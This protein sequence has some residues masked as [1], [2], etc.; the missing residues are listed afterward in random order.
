MSSGVRKI[1]NPHSAYGKRETLTNPTMR[2][3]WDI[4]DPY[5]WRPPRERSRCGPLQI[6]KTKYS[7][8]VRKIIT[9]QNVVTSSRV[10][11]STLHSKNTIITLT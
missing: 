5:R 8:N 11:L 9:K 10:L 7:K 1:D 4:Y 6:S 3:D 2:A